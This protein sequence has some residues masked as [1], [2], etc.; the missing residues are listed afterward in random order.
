[1]SDNKTPTVEETLKDLQDRVSKLEK[2]A[3]DH[4]SK[5]SKLER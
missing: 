2:Q 5:F 3:E 1:M 4:V